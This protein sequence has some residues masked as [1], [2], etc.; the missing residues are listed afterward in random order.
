MGS[1]GSLVTVVFE[2]VVGVV[3]G[4]VIVGVVAL[5]RRMRSPGQ[6]RN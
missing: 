4:G 2:G 5:G 1:L 3:A 6:P